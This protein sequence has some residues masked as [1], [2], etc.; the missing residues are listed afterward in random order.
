MVGGM[1]LARLEVISSTWGAAIVA[2]SG[3]F[4]LAAVFCAGIILFTTQRW[5][6]AMLGVTGAIPLL[7]VSVAGID[8]LRYPRL[9]EVTTDL[10]NPPQFSGITALPHYS[11]RD[12][13]FDVSTIGSIK[14]NYPHLQPLELGLTPDTA[15]QKAL[16]TAR[17]ASW[18]ILR[19]DQAERMFEAT[20]STTVLRR[21]Q[22]IVIRITPGGPEKSRVDARVRLRNG[23]YDIGANAR[24]IRIYFDA[25]KK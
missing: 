24:R 16:K 12:L 2:V 9:V 4:G 1:I 22:D 23:D 21:R 17:D 18:E 25:L 3:L 20:T 6:L 19:E 11:G 8:L 10:E 14:S 13:E 7:I 15:Y 5:P